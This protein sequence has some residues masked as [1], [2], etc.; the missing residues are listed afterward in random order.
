MALDAAGVSIDEV[1]RDARRR[2]DALTEYESEQEKQLEEYWA[3]KEARNA[4]IQAELDRA[5]SQSLSTMKR[6]LG[7]VA[8]DKAMFTKWQSMKQQ[9]AERISEGM[10]LCSKPVTS[11]EPANESVSLL[12]LRGAGP[13]ARPS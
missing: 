13:T 6:N 7:E 5:T 11:S 1:L 9:E 12:A 2:L 4:Q 8:L 3:R 10:G